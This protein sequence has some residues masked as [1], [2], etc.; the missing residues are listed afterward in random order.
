MNVVDEMCKFPRDLSGEVLSVVRLIII[1]FF[2]SLSL[3]QSSTK[4]LSRSHRLNYPNPYIMSLATPI[5]PLADRTTWAKCNPAAK[6]QASCE[7]TRKL[8][9]AE[10]ATRKLATEQKKKGQVALN[11]AISTYLLE[12]TEKFEAMAAEHNV[13]VKKIEDM[14]NSETHYKRPRAP[15]LQNA[16]VH[17]MAKKINDSKLVYCY[18]PLSAS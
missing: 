17:F 11:A 16:I 7:P 9:D 1:L 6:V 2:S 12:R 3:V 18:L 5:V 13:K 10:K 8:T 14:V 4:I 15:T